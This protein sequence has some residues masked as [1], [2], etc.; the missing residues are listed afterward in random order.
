[1]KVMKRIRISLMELLIPL[2]LLLEYR[3]FFMI[4]LPYTIDKLN[5]Y[6]TRYLELLCVLVMCLA[7]RRYKKEYFSYYNNVIVFILIIIVDLICTLVRY[8]GVSMH[9]VIAPFSAYLLILLYFPLSGYFRSEGHF[10][11]FKRL[12]LRFNIVACALLVFQAFVYNTRHWLF[13]KVYEITYLD[14]LQIRGGLL[15][16]TYLTT[17][18]SISVVISATEL[19][20]AKKHVISNS[21]NLIVSAVYFGYVAQTRMYIIVLLLVGL[22][23]FYFL[24]NDT[25]KFVVTS[26][27]LIGTALIVFLAVKLDVKTMLYKLIQPLFNGSYIRNG[28]YYARF[29]A[30]F[31]FSKAILQYPL[32]GL[33]IIVPDTTSDYYYVIHGPHGWAVY[34]DVGI[35]GTTAEFGLPMLIWFIYMMART[36]KAIGELHS[37]ESFYSKAFFVFILLSCVSLSIFDPQRVIILPLVLAINDRAIRNSSKIEGFSYTENDESKMLE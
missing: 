22:Y 32:T 15:R 37:E 24:K 25:N 5:T 17:I 14:D 6:H 9:E 4:P 3:F 33:G 18:V 29:E 26:T 19:F 36:R 28:S 34:T 31:H 12:L 21:V 2:W 16:I 35:L 30:L 7:Y 27:L 1:M 20:S 11:S 8:S 13:L 10:E 23:V